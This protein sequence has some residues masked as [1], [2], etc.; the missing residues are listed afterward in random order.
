MISCTKEHKVLFGTHMLLEETKDLL[1][2]VYQILEVV[3][4]EIT[5]AA[6]RAYFLE[7]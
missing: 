5:W 7:N 2:N 6:F 4:T 1:D 3:G